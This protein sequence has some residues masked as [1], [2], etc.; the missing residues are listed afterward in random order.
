MPSPS[1]SLNDTE[2]EI[3]C[4]SPALRWSSSEGLS[5]VYEQ[6]VMEAPL[7]IELA[8][9]KSGHSVRRLLGVT[10]RT[11]GHDEEL[12]LGLLHA[13]GLIAAMAD[14]QAS[15][16]ADTTLQGE[17][18]ATRCIV[19]T[20]PPVTLF[21]AVSRSLLTSSACGLCGRDGIK[22]LPLKE[23]PRDAAALRVSCATLASLPEKLRP[24]QSTFM[25]TGGCH[26]AAVCDAS[27]E[28][29]LCREDVGR[30]NA[31]DK[32]IGAALQKSLSLTGKI[33]VLS[34]RASFELVQKAS[35]ARI[36][37]VVAVGAPSSAA[38]ALAQQTGI[39]LVG[40]ARE[41]R[42]NIYAHAE[43]LDL[44]PAR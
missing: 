18:M 31:V 17:S 44:A 25:I 7:A 21:H 30:H 29:L 36:G 1:S 11:P 37:I 6:I 35:M 3:I 32:L 43:G 8:Y 42:F 14:V 23:I 27:G 2:N 26:G 5:S 20:K 38:V 15:M 12:A 10:M 39:T 33:L 41:N 34:S 22:D 13:E 28:V 19:L 24:L 16:A 4:G 9:E 40:F